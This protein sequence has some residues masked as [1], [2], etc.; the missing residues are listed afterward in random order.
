MK[1]ILDYVWEIVKPYKIH[2]Y[3]ALFLIFIIDGI[4][5]VT[6][7]LVGKLID[8]LKTDIQGSGWIYHGVLAGLSVI[9]VT[10]LSQIKASHE[11]K[12]YIFQ[13]DRS[14]EIDSFKKIMKFS[15]GQLFQNNSGEIQS[16]I[17]RGTTS[18]STFVSLLLFDIIPAITTIII[19]IAMLFT[20]SWQMNIIVIC[21]A[22]GMILFLWKT[23]VKFG[24]GF[25]ILQ[26]DWQ[27]VDTLKTEILRNL[28]LVKFTN[29][30]DNLLGEYKDIF[31]KTESDSRSH[32][33][34]YVNRTF[35]M[36]LL[37]AIT[38][39]CILVLG[40]MLVI[41][42]NYSAGTFVVIYSWSADVLSK[43]K[44]LRRSARMLV[45][46]IPGMTKFLDLIDTQPLFQETGT[47]LEIPYG[48]ISF[49]N[50]HFKYENS[51]KETLRSINIEILPGQSIGIVGP[52]GS[53]KSTLVKL[54]L[55]VWDPTQ[56]GVYIDNI[57]LPNYHKSYRE[58]FGY[59]PQNTMLFDNTIRYNLGLGL[60]NIND[61]VLWEVLKKVQLFNKIK[62]TEHGLSTIIGEQGIKLSGGE[63]QRLVIARTILRKP[64]ILIF[65]E[66]TSS[67]DGE[68]QEL[69]KK[70]IQEVSKSVTAIIIA[71]RISTV[72]DC[73]QIIVLKDGEVKEIDS[74]ENLMKTSSTFKKMVL[75]ESFYP[76][77]Q[78]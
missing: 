48:G 38:I 8:N 37:Y 4:G 27:K 26:E 25:I 78:N 67:L 69:M 51:E 30:E 24:E 11:L 46:I 45:K 35:V 68:N 77:N 36:E 49:K 61:F 10:V 47:I 59:V 75:A 12:Y 65:D 15:I 53:G 72:Q 16:V 56:G 43:I 70:A 6:P 66:A 63:S 55:R 73:D 33:I 31:K 29:Q 14:F 42:G 5:L 74:P 28:T 32:W 7:F 40:S 17:Q 60:T 2:L 71:H 23:N 52:S 39:T 57:P 21:F 1:K 41:K 13:F 18:F 76:L 34:R 44:Y 50:V 62:A 9:L 3:L 64:K 54:L 22:F 20:I 58:S 19:T